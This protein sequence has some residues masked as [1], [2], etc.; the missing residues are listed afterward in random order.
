MPGSNLCSMKRT[1]PWKLSVPI[2]EIIPFRARKTRTARVIG[3]GALVYAD[4]SQNRDS[5]YVFHFDK[6]LAM[7]GNT[8]T[9]IRR[10]RPNPLDFLQRE[11]R[12]ANPAS[13]ARPP[14][15]RVTCP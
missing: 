5:D 2:T 1:A 14:A 11:C 10:I 9:Y 6:M 3:I 4:L 13:Q 7:N 12:S 8:A 15:E